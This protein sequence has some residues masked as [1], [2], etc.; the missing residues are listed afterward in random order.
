[1]T[2]FPAARRSISSAAERT[3]PSSPRSTRYANRGALNAA[4]DAGAVVL[5][6]CA[7][8]QLIGTTLPGADGRP[9]SGLGLVDAVT[10]RAPKRLVGE[11]RC[12]TTRSAPAGSSGSRTT[13]ESTA[14]AS[15]AVPIGPR[16]PERGCETDGVVRGR[17]VG[18]YLHGPVL[19]R[20][21]QLADQLLDWVAGP[22]A[23]LPDPQ[24]D[25]L[26]E[27][28]YAAV[29]GARRWPQWARRRRTNR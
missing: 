27:E 16:E 23:P 7:G 19:A 2:R 8:F 1:M 5:A 14:I 4:A 21:P 15:G 24:A 11:V 9:V 28:R 20:N 26:H 6:V 10:T 12:A 3:R 29:I 25:L 17:V 13:G 18:T 22:L